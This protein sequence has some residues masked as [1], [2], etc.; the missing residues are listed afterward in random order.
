VTP[1][2]AVQI[3]EGFLNADSQDVFEVQPVLAQYS[4]ISY[5]ADENDDPTKK[6]T[7]RSRDRTERVD[8]AEGW[9]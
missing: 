2:E 1:D 6:L 3:A 4:K 7:A 8:A 5:L 9:I